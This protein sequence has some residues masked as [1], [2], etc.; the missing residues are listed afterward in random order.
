MHVWSLVSSLRSQPLQRS[1]AALVSLALT[2]QRR[3]KCVVTIDEEGDWVTR[4]SEWTI[5]SPSPHTIR[6]RDAN[7]AVRDLWCHAYVPRPGDTIVDVG[8]GV[9]DDLVVFS[10]LVGDTGRIVAIEAHPRTYRC[11]LKTIR[12]NGLKNVHPIHVAVGDVKSVVRID[13][14]STHLS[15]RVGA[16]GVEVPQL[17]LDTLLQQAGVSNV[18]LL[19]VNIEGAEWPALKGMATTLRRTRALVVSCH[20]FVADAGGQPTMRTYSAV[21]TFL[22]NSGLSIQDR[23]Q[24]PR[25]WVKYYCYAQGKV[26]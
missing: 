21:R 4:Q 1:A 5:Y 9:G 16:A 3:A 24:D 20:D 2:L 8:A 15:A 12:A 7:E 25:P 19:K 17:D 22:E 14:G 13:D 18:A 26:T 23:P 10:R 6:Y 11:L